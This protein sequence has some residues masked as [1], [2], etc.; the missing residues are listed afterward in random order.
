MRIIVVLI[1][2][3]YL[4]ACP[5]LCAV[6]EGAGY[7]P[8]WDGTIAVFPDGELITGKS[9]LSHSTD[10]GR[11]WSTGSSVS[12]SAAVTAL[13]IS[14]D[15]AVYCFSPYSRLL[16]ESHDRGRTWNSTPQIF[17]DS[18]ELSSASETLAIDAKGRRWLFGWPPIF[19]SDGEARWKP[20]PI[21]GHCDV[22]SHVFDRFGRLY[23]C[24][25]EG[26]FRLRPDLS[27]WDH[28]TRDTVSSF[29]L[30]D[31]SVLFAISGTAV[32]RSVDYGSRWDT[33]HTGLSNCVVHHS[34]CKDTVMLSYR[35]AP[36]RSLRAHTYRVV[37]LI[38]DS[39]GWRE[40]T[41]EAL[42]DTPL[43][44][45]HITSAGTVWVGQ[46]TNPQ[47]S[48][49]SSDVLVVSENSGRS[50]RITSLSSSAAF[51]FT[52]DRK[53]WL[54]AGRNGPGGV[55]R[56]R[57]AGKS[58][59]AVNDGLDALLNVWTL[60]VDE[61]DRPVASGPSGVFRKSGERWERIFSDTSASLTVMCMA[62]G[63]QMFVH[64]RA[65]NTSGS[66][67]VRLTPS[68]NG[69]VVAEN[70]WMS[71]PSSMTTLDGRTFFC[72]QDIMDFRSRTQT[73]N[74]YR[75]DDSGRTW[76]SVPGST[77]AVT[78]KQ[79]LM[80]GNGTLLAIT[81]A[82]YENTGGR[83]P[84]RNIFSSTDSGRTWHTVDILYNV[85]VLRLAATADGTVWAIGSSLYRSRDNGASW[86]HL[87]GS[88]QRALYGDE[89]NSL[90]YFAP[91][92][93]PDGRTI[94]FSKE[95]NTITTTAE[96]NW[97]RVL[98]MGYRRGFHQLAGTPDG[99][100]YGLD[101]RADSLWISGVG[102]VSWSAVQLPQPVSRFASLY[103]PN[104]TDIH[105]GGVL[106]S[107]DGGRTW[108]KDIAG[109]P[110]YREVLYVGGFPSG[111]LVAQLRDY[112]LFFSGD[113]GRTWKS[114]GIRRYFTDIAIRGNV[115]Y[116][117]G[118][119]SLYRV[120]PPTSGARWR[121]R[122]RPLPKGVSGKQLVTT[123]SELVIVAFNEN[124][125]HR[126]YRSDNDGRIWQKV[127]VKLPL[128]RRIYC[129]CAVHK[130]IFIGAEGG[131]F[132]SY[133]GGETWESAGLTYET[134]LSL[135]ASGE[136]LFAST[137]DAVLMLPLTRF[138]TAG[139]TIQQ[140]LKGR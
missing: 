133:D 76:L 67:L 132:A 6:Q 119:D 14:G 87:H 25:T 104:D 125:E 48:A 56:S 81:P 128:H 55:L 135:T 111:V 136:Y 10:R 93:L 118:G 62:P 88:I 73:G 16:W 7:P 96:Q 90:L 42:S 83:R 134:V 139:N 91:V 45:A 79:V 137:R 65:W 115:L 8:G 4:V 94:I 140:Q 50:W 124:E 77:P 39:T 138:T 54:Y 97:Q 2:A 106:Y 27:V 101:D 29:C 19:V 57:D 110:E 18:S 44:P 23:L 24:S 31:D 116:A 20:V 32:L 34:V 98:A 51:C 92:M 15:S 36:E 84:E 75:S 113:R 126:V 89:P 70:T 122:A 66:N 21:P 59:E 49:G 40:E 82:H 58:W 99:V 28:L 41:C 131:I 68:E 129:L 71:Y 1:F 11:T 74:L 69:S 13:H 17:P 107:H 121:V 127:I 63:G 102:A 130:V 5:P 43:R 53:G 78:F 61:N 109:L 100:V 86:E 117:V 22:T 26:L 108:N 37:L 123:G 72:T 114:T 64:A 85:T 30:A 52:A 60:A 120:E 47:Y 95:H 9:F 103:A 12:P 33:I 105:I 3:G 46:V 80:C 38:R 112:G 35:I